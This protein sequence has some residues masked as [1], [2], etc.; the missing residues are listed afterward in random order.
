MQTTLNAVAMDFAGE[1]KSAVPVSS[2]GPGSSRL[3]RLAIEGRVRRHEAALVLAKQ[4]ELG[5][6]RQP[7]QSIDMTK[8]EQLLARRDIE[9]IS[10]DTADRWAR[11]DAADFRRITENAEREEVAS[12]WI[13]VACARSERYE[14]ALSKVA[15]DVASFAK[16]SAVTR[17]TGSAATKPAKVA[18]AIH[19]LQQCESQA[20]EAARNQ[21]LPQLKQL[22]E[23]IE[24]IVAIGAGEVLEHATALLLK[25]E[26]L[27]GDV[28]VTHADAFASK[29][30]T[31]PRQVDFAMS[32]V[33]EAAD[34][35]AFHELTLQAA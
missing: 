27:I 24:R 10:V 25:I 26:R 22:A 21:N 9:V 4:H 28:Q 7:G 12:Y 32:V 13:A 2:R 29:G 16:T 20:D 23:R 6:L 8:V 3:L 34:G 17:Y 1:V 19:I 30:C 15:P 18:I 33:T 35:A 11:L 31:L 14:T 5:Q